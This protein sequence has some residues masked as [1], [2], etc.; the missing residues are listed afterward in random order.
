[1]SSVPEELSGE[2]V[3]S[4]SVLGLAN[5]GHIKIQHSK[6]YSKHSLFIGEGLQ[7]MEN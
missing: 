3:L 5:D 1:M 2:H 7:D 6:H 4:W